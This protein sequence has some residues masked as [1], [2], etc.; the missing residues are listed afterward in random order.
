MS[1]ADVD[2]NK[3]TIA[4]AR[5]QRSELAA[6]CERCVLSRWL[7]VLGPAALGMRFSTAEVLEPTR[8]SDEHD[9]EL[10][11][12][13]GWTAAPTLLP[14]IDQYGWLDNHRALS[15]R[16]ISAITARRQDV[17]VE[18]ADN[19][20]QVRPPSE[21]P[22]MSLQEVADAYD[23]L[24]ERVTALLLLTRDLVSEMDSPVVVQPGDDRPSGA[25][26]ARSGDEA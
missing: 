26:Q 13:D 5:L 19:Y 17:A 25:E 20:P 1:I 3:W 15:T 18:P 22:I 16:T 4:G 21:A 23:D 9:C 14:A 6:T 8:H 2:G 11:L 12:D 10:P 24:D 7:R